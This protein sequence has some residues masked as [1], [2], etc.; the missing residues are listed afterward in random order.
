[1][2]SLAQSCSIALSSSKLPKIQQ[3]YQL[4]AAQLKGTIIRSH[5][6][7]SNNRPNAL[8]RLNERF[9]NFRN[10]TQYSFKAWSTRRL[11]FVEHLNHLVPAQILPRPCWSTS[12]LTNVIRTPA[13]S[14]TSR[15]ILK[16]FCLCSSLSGIRASKVV[17][18]YSRDLH[19]TFFFG[20]DWSC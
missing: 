1:M 8:Q 14:G 11:L 19:K 6:G 17:W 5:P 13:I 10:Q 9:D 12:W 18:L 4:F 15:W 20:I 16:T 7:V 2:F 3:F